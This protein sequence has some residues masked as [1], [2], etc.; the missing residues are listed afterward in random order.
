MCPKLVLA[1]CND[2]ANGSCPLS[3]DEVRDGGSPNRES[4]YTSQGLLV[5]RRKVQLARSLQVSGCD[6]AGYT[7]YIE[8]RSSRGTRWARSP[9]HIEGGSSRGTRWSRSPKYIEGGSSRGTRWARSRS[10]KYIEGAPAERLGGLDPARP[11]SRL[12]LQRCVSDFE[13]R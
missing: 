11:T 7:L 6:R 10:P 8:I 4:Q 1:A 9:K 3:V 2:A 12:L 13:A 5:T